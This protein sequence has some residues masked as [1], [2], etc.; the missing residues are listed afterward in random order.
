MLKKRA[1]VRIAALEK[2]ADQFDQAGEAELNQQDRPAAAA[3]C[4]S[5]RWLQIGQHQHPWHHVAWRSAA[6]AS[7]DST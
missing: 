7:R 2:Q 1:E 5:G 6:A 3:V 4:F